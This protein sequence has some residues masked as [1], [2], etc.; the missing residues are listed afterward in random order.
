MAELP[1]LLSTLVATLLAI[2]GAVLL[3]YEG[4]YRMGR[5]LRAG[6][7]ASGHRQMLAAILGL[8]ALHM[9]EIWIFGA[10]WWALGAIPDAG[11]VSGL[12][13]VRW[14][15]ALFL[16]VLA[17][18]SLGFDTLVPIGMLRILAGAEAL[19]GLVL[20]AWSASFAFLQMQRHWKI[21]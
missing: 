5:R 12:A 21:G 6:A 1:G 10:A 9:V 19:T 2:A 13:S 18:T 16:S 14:H 3:H 7:T 17:F 4:L 20:V 8:M 15:D 11:Q